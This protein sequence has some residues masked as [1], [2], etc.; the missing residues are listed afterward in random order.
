MAT[1]L[2]IDMVSDVSCPWCAIGLHA[3]ERALADLADTVTA[4]LRFQPF[5]LNPTMPPAGEDIGAHL[6]R[7]YGS[8]PAQQA[9]LQA[10]ICRRG[11]ELGFR[12]AWTAG[13][14]IYNTFDAHRLLHWAGLPDGH[15]SGCQHALKKALFA[16]YFSDGESPASHAV[17]LRLADRVG[18]D[19]GRAAAI[20]AGDAYAADVRGRERRYLEAG[21]RS[22]PAVIVDD[23][24]LIAGGQ[25]A[26]VFA[27][28]LARIAADRAA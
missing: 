13:M 25:P 17:L 14:R 12:F 10:D 18:L 20:L 5:E 8:T 11:A 7:K 22:V 28:A 23:R 26:H 1:V 21:I 2:R 6:A 4:D 16:A 19:S 9:E 27:A 24:Y 15:P 3:L